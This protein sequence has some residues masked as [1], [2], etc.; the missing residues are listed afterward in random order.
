[1]IVPKPKRRPQGK[2]NGRLIAPPPPPP[3]IRRINEDV[4]MGR[5]PGRDTPNVIM[6]RLEGK[7]DALSTSVNKQFILLATMFDDF[8]KSQ[9]EEVENLFERPEFKKSVPVPSAP[10]V[11]PNDVRISLCADS[12]G[13]VISFNDARL[14]ASEAEKETLIVQV[15]CLKAELALVS[16]REAYPDPD[17]QYGSV[18]VYEEVMAMTEKFRKRLAEEKEDP[19]YYSNDIEIMSDEA[20]SEA[21]ASEKEAPHNVTMTNAR[22][23]RRREREERKKFSQDKL[24]STFATNVSKIFSHPIYN[25]P[26]GPKK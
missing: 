11:P 1:M 21:L 12:Q 14:R 19:N 8:V 23:I 6:Q 17:D 22:D 16:K 3:D 15:E 25:K 7:V 5:A 24:G 26:K 2:P 18:E 4:S 9:T 13:G 20:M 10:I